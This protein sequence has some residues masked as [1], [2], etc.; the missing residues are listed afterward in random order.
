MYE[1]KPISDE[2]APIPK[3]I[4]KEAEKRKNEHGKQISPWLS[5]WVGVGVSIGIPI[6]HSC[7]E[8]PEN[9]KD[10]DPAHSKTITFEVYRNPLDTES[11]T[12]PDSNNTAFGP[13]I[14]RLRT[15]GMSGNSTRT[16]EP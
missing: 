8:K 10:Y 12:R 2:Y 5:I 13:V 6:V 4:E 7:F 1:V 9:P 11:V 14:R 15:H 3:V 16:K